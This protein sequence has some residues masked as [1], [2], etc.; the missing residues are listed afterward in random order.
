MWMTNFDSTFG[1]LYKTFLQMW[2][3]ECVGITNGKAHCSSWH[4]AY[5]TK[6]AN[7][8]GV[9]MIKPNGES[10]NEWINEMNERE[11][12]AYV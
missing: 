12:N 10:M 7:R 6:Y 5:N 2:S 9:I 3:N 8:Y 11:W 4:G 1:D